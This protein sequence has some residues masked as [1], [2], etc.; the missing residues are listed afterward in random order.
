MESKNECRN[1]PLL[2]DGIS[3]TGKRHAKESREKVAHPLFPLNIA[4][5]IDIFIVDRV[6]IF[7]G[8]FI[9]AVIFMWFALD[10]WAEDNHKALPFDKSRVVSAEKSLSDKK[11][12]RKKS[13]TIIEIKN[14]N[15]IIDVEN[16]NL[17]D[18]F[19]AIGIKAGVKINIEKDVINRKITAKYKGT[20][21]ETALKKI[22]GKNYAL[23]FSKDLSAQNKYI[24]K[25]IRVAEMSLLKTISDKDY[26]AKELLN[27]SH[28]T[29]IRSLVDNS[30]AGINGLYK[31]HQEIKDSKGHISSYSFF[32]AVG[33]NEDMGHIYQTVRNAEVK[34]K[35][36]QQ[37][38]AEAR[39][40]ADEAKLQAAAKL[41]VQGDRELTREKDYATVSIAATTDQPPLLSFQYGLPD[42]VIMLDSAV[43]LAQGKSGEECVLKEIRQQGIFGV[44][45]VLETKNGRI[46]YSDPKQGMVFTEMRE[47]TGKKKESR[48]NV[49]EDEARN[50]RIRAQWVEFLERGFDPKIFTLNNLT[51]LSKKEEGR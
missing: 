12:N 50:R 30:M 5:I 18:V 22:L 3:F 46:L 45:F 29:Q 44:I 36:G 48:S 51:D 9:L 40:E 14:N 7:V 1:S 6:Q 31:G 20:E 16:A 34:R 23:V 33:L 15:I 17:F 38:L 19:E 13:K 32:Y 27:S 21:I 37:L 47:V 25:E 41:L 8:F 42:W 28:L 2:V 35:E 10:A 49:S 26:T 43:E 4:R 39:A 24:L 11:I